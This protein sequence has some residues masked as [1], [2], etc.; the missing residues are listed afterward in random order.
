MFKFLKNLFS[1]DARPAEKTA[2]QTTNT[3]AR[4]NF[5]RREPILNRHQNIIGYEF[6]LERPEQK[7]RA[8]HPSTQRFFDEALLN[9]L[10]TAEVAPL[11][12]RR[13]AF[14]PLHVNALEQS[15]LAKLNPAKTVIHVQI[16][17][18]PDAA[19]IPTLF[20]A[21]QAL[22]SAGFSLAVP[23]NL[24]SPD[25]ADMM[26]LAD[27][28]SVNPNGMAPP[29]LMAHTRGLRKTFPHSRLLAHG[30]DSNELFEAC[31]GLHFDLFQG[32]YLVQRQDS[33]EP[34]LSSQRL[35][36]TELISQLKHRDTD[37]DKLA[38]IA[39]QDLG[40]TVRLLRYINSAAMG[41]SN[42]VA[43][44]EQA[45][46][47][48][49]HDGLYRWL[50]LLLFYNSKTSQVDEALRETALA[51]ARLCELLAKKRLSKKECE[52]AFVAGLLSMV[53][54]LFKM[55]MDKAIAQLGLPEEL[56]AALLHQEGRYGAF[57]GLALACEAGDANGIDRLAGKCEVSPAQVNALHLEALTWAVDYDASLGAGN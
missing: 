11:L 36:V 8:W 42:K 21:L 32:H 56:R 13:I 44:L 25:T 54:V 3:A 1:D 9:H 27:V 22:K 37:F 18:K 52:Q 28:I 47:Y 40:L 31:R 6:N 7:Q 24:A 10:T 50:T 46:T 23:S 34:D 55:P 53:D 39:R 17:D 15:P 30:V 48:I 41:L 26:Q 4:P 5:L 49:G 38:M 19:H 29:D 20:A 12:G 33:P 43:S 51:R 2:P 16:T 57:L 35:V 45:M 14:V